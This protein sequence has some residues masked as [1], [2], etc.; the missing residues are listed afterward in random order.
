M[1]GSDPANWVPPLLGAIL[2]L[3]CLAPALRAGRRRR[4]VD[5]LPTSKTTGVFIGLA[6]LKGTAESNTPLTSYLA[7]GACVLFN[8]SIEERWSRTV[9]ETYTD[10]N[11][12]TQTRTRHE[13][14]WTSVD[15]G[16]AMIPF[17]LQD[18]RGIVQILPAGAKIE[19]IVVFSET[20]GRSDPL[21][22]GKGPD[23]S[24]AHSDGVRR[25]SEQA[26]P[27]H[28]EIYVMGQARERTDIVAPEIA[29]DPNAPLFLISTR[30]EEQVSS[31]HANAFWGWNIFGAVLAVA[32][33]IVRDVMASL[34]LEQ[35]WPIYLLPLVG[36][37]LAACVG[38][39]WMVFNSLVELRQRVRQG[40]AQVEVQLKRRHDLIPNLVEVVQGFRD[41]E[42]SLQTELATLR[43]QM[44][45]T[46][47]G[48]AG[49]DFR[50]L[51]QTL[52]A[53][54]ERYPE[55]RAHT[56][57]EKLQRNL[58]DTE[59]RIAM[60]RGYFNDIATHWNTRLETVPERYVARLGAMQPTALMSADEFERA[61]VKV[62]F[63]VAPGH[64]PSPV[65]VS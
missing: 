32:G 24:V 44:Q 4:L 47:P 10:S 23:R 27:L 52:I 8:W 40:W 21:Y 57:F 9:T 25:F 15:S 60:A 29:A 5:Q 54:A 11:G 39:I 64:A 28:A 42:Q 46:P 14:G 63:A 38:W 58:I 51:K 1:P 2:A 17:H 22:F 19:P 43:T 48:V 31:S 61:P 34:P 13:S 35:R 49:P 3:L 20:C 56:T 26:I 30:T 62:D 65:S 55:L 33:F 16:G 45:A 50:A 59:E 53:V 7:E 12:K 37:F 6:E 41:Y 36:Y 18:D